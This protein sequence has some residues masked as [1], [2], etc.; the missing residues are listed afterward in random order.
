MPG[1]VAG[2]LVAA[3]YYWGWDVSSNLNEETKDSRRAAGIGGVIGVVIVFALFE[4]FTIVVNMTL[5][6]KAI[7]ANSANVLAVLGQEAWPGIGGKLLVLS[8]MLSTI[9]TLETTL[10]QVT[11]SLFAMARDRTVPAALGWVHPRWRTPWLATVVVAVVSLS[12]FIGSNFIG[13]LSTILNDRG[14]RR[15]SRASSRAGRTT[16]VTCG[17][18]FL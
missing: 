11:R 12:L 14:Q 16:L 15:A 2:A 9:A 5:P 8:V 18:C 10:I 4:I 7:S 1:F 17:G 13:S 6:A 3:F